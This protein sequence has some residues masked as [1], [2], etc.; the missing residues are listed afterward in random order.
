MSDE[1][2]GLPDESAGSADSAVVGAGAGA[3]TGTGTDTDTANQQTR[4]RTRIRLDGDR[5]TGK[6]IPVDVTPELQRYER[7]V[8]EVA[9][10]QWKTQNPEKNLPR[11]FRDQFQ[12]SIVDVED[13]SATPVLERVSNSA[14]DTYFD[15]AAESVD[16]AFE[17]IIAGEEEEVS[18]WVTKLP[19][20]RDFGSTLEA[21]EAIEFRPKTPAVIRYT[22]EIRTVRFPKA[23]TRKRA[24]ADEDP[25]ALVGRLTALDAN[26]WKF[27][28]TDL[29]G[30]EVQGTYTNP[31]LTDDIKAV[32]NASTV[33]PVA[34]VIAY[35]AADANG[36]LARIVDVESV[37]LFESE[38]EP[39]TRRLIEL[40]TLQAGWSEGTG[41]AIAFA[42][43][44]AV[45]EILRQL[46]VTVDNYP[47]IFPSENGGVLVE[48][49]S[50][51][52]VISVEVNPEIEYSLFRLNPEV[53][54][55]DELETRNI[56]AAV[57]F[58]RGAL[59]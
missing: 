30:R 3:G 12:L 59:A 20:F 41:E 22:P 54:A 56:R 13:G 15:H 48:W 19:D 11:F 47:G 1:E 45:R 46:E 43:L 36:Q 34:R 24:V 42:A 58:L 8:I 40:A 32:L 14:Y 21:G 38:R 44:D 17:A 18:A 26:H 50:I 10:Q 52:R 28:L 53:R 6:R 49:A 29:N 4:R 25:R 7:L 2:S 5:F 16:K 31:D 39:W 55:T 37:E 51:Q 33:A 23:P 35:I 9:A 27:T 57:D